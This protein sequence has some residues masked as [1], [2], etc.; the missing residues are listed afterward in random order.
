[1]SKKKYFT[2]IELLVVVAIIGI[3]AAM[4]LPALGAAR[5]KA[6]ISRCRGN[7]KSIG[8]T[9]RMYFIE[10]PDAILPDFAADPIIN[11]SH[12]WVSTMGISSEILTC[13]AKLTKGSN[14]NYEIIVPNLTQYGDIV[15]ETESILVEDQES[16][17]NSENV[18]RLH[19]DGHVSSGK[20]SN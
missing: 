16:H 7:L 5:D 19:P 9:I 11:S 1:M 15:T 12:I 13:A 6:H 3:L 17:E 8:T 18:N 14:G 2:L 4:I 20:P 10:E